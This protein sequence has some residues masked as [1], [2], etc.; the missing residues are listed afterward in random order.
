MSVAKKKDNNISYSGGAV[1]ISDMKSHADDPFFVKKAD[2][3]RVAVSKL[4]LPGEK[5]K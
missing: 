3:A 1:V 5:K 4:V 2:E